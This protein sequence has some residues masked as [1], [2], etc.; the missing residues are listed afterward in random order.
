MESAVPVTKESIGGLTFYAIFGITDELAPID[1]SS[2]QKRYRRLSVVLHPDKDPSPEARAAFERLR[3]ALDTLTND[4]LRAE[5]D[6]S[7]RI[8]ATSAASK[9]T[10][11]RAA[12]AVAQREQ[13]TAALRQQQRA[14]AAQRQAAEHRVHT[15][16]MGRLKRC[17]LRTA[18]EDM[19]DDWDVD[20]DLLLAKLAAVQRMLDLTQQSAKRWRDGLPVA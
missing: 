8:A 13:A 4:Q 5:Y 19:L 14:D 1:A 16:L 12:A 11:T 6:E 9:D 3:L 2:V 10:A 15:E 20:D 17:P 18:E 7:R